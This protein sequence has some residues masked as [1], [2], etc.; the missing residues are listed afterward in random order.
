MMS[1][2]LALASIGAL[3]AVAGNAS[4]DPTNFRFEGNVVFHEDVYLA[5]LAQ[6]SATGTVTRDAQAIAGILENFL[7]RA[8]YPLADVAARTDPD[9]V[10]LRIDEGQLERIIL[11]RENGLVALA[12][13]IAV[14]LPHSVFNRPLFERQL[15]RLEED[16]GIATARYELMPVTRSDPARLDLKALGPIAP[17]VGRR[18][19][20]W[21]LRIELLHENRSGGPRFRLAYRSPAG[22]I[23]GGGY[24]FRNTLATEDELSVD[25]HI[26]LRVLD[27]VRAENQGR[28]VLS[29]GFVGLAWSF[30]AF[31]GGQ[32]RLNLEPTFYLENRQ[33]L[34]LGITSYNFVILD[35]AAGL[36]TDIFTGID[37]LLGAGLQYQSVV[38]DLSGIE[39]PPRRDP[40]GGF[41][42]YLALRLDL[43]VSENP[44][45]LR[46]SERHNV[47]VNARWFMTRGFGGGDIEYKKSFA[48]G[49]DRLDL[50]IHATG[51]AGSVPFT[52]EVSAGRHLIGVFGAEAFSTRLVSLHLEYRLSLTRDLLAIGFFHGGVLFSELDRV[53]D[54]LDLSLANAFGPGL[55]ALFLDTFE[56]SVY[57]AIGFMS[58]GRRELAMALVIRQV[59]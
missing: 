8:G 12:V 43:D 46:A 3:A 39:G 49:W 33:R 16:Y 32:L 56:L 19:A 30:P 14:D 53:E 4:A 28:Q 20:R 2:V 34:D 24:L 31:V 36:R 26:G 50:G 25:A 7:H 11:P 51:L 38:T 54:N 41:R 13:Q 10:T 1:S 37:F 45:V 47:S 23:L 29:R 18:P 40:E 59:F 17:A 55:H 52:D 58:K 42:P 48:F 44:N 27:L 9:G 22:L 21:T 5:L 6:H 15:R 35:G 57:G